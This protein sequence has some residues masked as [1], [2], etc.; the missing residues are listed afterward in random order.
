MSVAAPPVQTSCAGFRRAA[1][2]CRA[3]ASSCCSSP[4]SLSEPARLPRWT[5]RTPA[6]CP[7]GS[8][9]WV[10]VGAAAAL[11]AHLAVRW[12]APYVRPGAAAGRRSRST[13][14]G[15]ALIHRLDVAADERAR[16]RGSAPPLSFA[17]HQVIWSALGVVLF[18]GVLARRARAADR[19]QRLTYTAMLVGLVLLLLPL[20]PAL[21]AHHQR[22]PDLDPARRL[23]FQPGEVA[24]LALIVFFAGYLVAKRDV[25]SLATQPGPRHR[26]AARS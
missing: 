7:T 24:K 4:P 22:R 16:A 17:E 13:A 5:W 21:G 2:R 9:P 18:I 6:S 23:S 19:S 11:V 26:P 12:L 15:L 1:R 20:L 25:L 10:G 14:L 3:A 8:G